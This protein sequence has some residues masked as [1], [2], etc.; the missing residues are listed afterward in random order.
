MPTEDS[1]S[2]PAPVQAASLEPV[3]DLE[4]AAVEW[5]PELIVPMPAPA[6]GDNDVQQ[7]V[8]TIERE[9]PEPGQCLSKSGTRFAT[10]WR[11][12]QWQRID[13]SFICRRCFYSWPEDMP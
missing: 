7:H 8:F 11:S 6:P 5:V 3:E 13:N 9:A 10:F 2:S 1:T 12:H 4:P